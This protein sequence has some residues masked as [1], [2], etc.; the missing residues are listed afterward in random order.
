MTECVSTEFVSTEFV[1]TAW[2]V[3]GISWMVDV[4][5]Q[6]AHI[7]SEEED[8][9]VDVSD[10]TWNSPPFGHGTN[11]ISIELP[12]HRFSQEFESI[13]VRKDISLKEL[14]QN[15]YDFY[16][17]PID[18]E[19]V[20]KYQED[21]LGFVATAKANINNGIPTNWIDLMGD[22]IYFEDFENISPTLWRMSLGS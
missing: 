16:Q 7:Y 18:N 17:S 3:E 5:P 11:I 22:N 13:R 4:P 14:F 21:C 15:I 19:K 10:Q 9:M 6:N 20:M 12:T 2:E 1:S 8:D